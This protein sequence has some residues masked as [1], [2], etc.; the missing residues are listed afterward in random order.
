MCRSHVITPEWQEIRRP[1]GE[2]GNCRVPLHTITNSSCLPVKILHTVCAAFEFGDC[3][4]RI[5][6]TWCK[7]ADAMVAVQ[8]VTVRIWRPDKEHTPHLTHYVTNKKYP[9]HTYTHSHSHFTSDIYIWSHCTTS[10]LGS[11]VKSKN[12]QVV[13]TDKRWC[14]AAWRGCPI[15]TPQMESFW[16]PS[17]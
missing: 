11:S 6:S 1:G 10:L 9:K 7:S 17:K 8:F 5:C 2:N 4:N 14:E 16:Q 15:I 12:S 3:S 13:L